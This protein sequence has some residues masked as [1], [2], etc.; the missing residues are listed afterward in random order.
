MILL[1]VTGSIAAYKAAEILRLLLKN[2]QE[3]QVLM[4]PAATQFVGPLTFQ[5]LSGRPVLLSPL[6]A[7]AWVTTAHISLTERASA[8][9]VA[10]ATA[11]SLARAAHG[12]ASDMISASLLSIP[13]DRSN[14]PTIPIFLAPA[15]HDAMWRHPATQANVKILQSYGYHFI[16]PEQGNL[17]RAGDRGW[18][19]MTEPAEIVKILLKSLTR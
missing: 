5:S 18:G 13:R 6:E 2:K 10:P 19:R 3:V 16:G 8:L 1:G 9:V 7:S 14:K 15:M 17:S 12:E 4:T 11:D